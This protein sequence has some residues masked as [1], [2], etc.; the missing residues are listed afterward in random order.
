MIVGN[1][2]PDT[3]PDLTHKHPRHINGVLTVSTHLSPLPSDTAHDSAPH[4]ASLP[5]SPTLNPQHSAAVAVPH[6]NCSARRIPPDTFESERHFYPRVL[7]ATLHPMVLTFLQLGNES[8][9]TR[10][11]HL[12]PKV[13]YEKLIA[14]LS[15]RPSIFQWAGADL[16]NVTN[17][18]GQ[19]QMIIIETN[20]CPSGQK[21]MP[22]VQNDT[23]LDGYHTMMRSTFMTAVRER[24]K[25]N[26]LPKGDLCV[27]YDK[28]PMETT[29][30]ATALA[31]AS[32]ENVWLVEFYED[33]QDP[34]VKFVPST[35]AHVPGLVMHVRDS[36]GNWHP[37]R[38]A[39]RYVT[40]RPWTRLPVSS[41]TYILNPIL[42][43]LAGGRNKMAAD[44]AYEVYNRENSG[45]GLEIRCPQTIRDVT[46]AEVPLWVKSMGGHAVVKVPYS[47]AGQGV[48]TITSERELADFLATNHFY[49]K[50]IV[51]SLVGNSHWS[52]MTRS[53]QFYHT[54]TIPNKKGQTFVTDLRMMISG[55]DS[56][57]QPVS[58]YA[59]RALLPLVDELTESSDSWGMLG[60]NLSVKK[61]DG[62]WMTESER[63]VMMDMK[64]FNKLGLG[65]DDLIDAY[66]QTV[67]AATAIDS[68]AKRLL[69]PDGSFN[70]DLYTSL[71]SDHALINEIM[72]V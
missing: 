11:C 30:Y 28:N 38:A 61:E 62:S 41:A 72:Q 52:S 6:M 35:E 40:Q 12:R 55:T 32:N 42:A 7:N 64:D 70:R 71:N 65:I 10:Y 14:V 47:N 36:D 48:Y 22:Q 51:Q 58:I 33:D 37:I 67:L 8:I 17:F 9:A 29:G 54:G 25:N 31:D 23:N 15:H 20:S 60:T 59:R 50:F 44:K 13:S 16:F 45:S 27:V 63:L 21:S 69:L 4:P 43:C 24:E 26:K 18:S 49:D 34:P 53:G 1:G 3:S 66:V 5:S 39:F 2:S 68:M 56:G 57:F 46:R 19:R